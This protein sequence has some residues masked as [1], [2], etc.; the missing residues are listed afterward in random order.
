MIIIKKFTQLVILLQG[1][2]YMLLSDGIDFNKK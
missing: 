2:N 1:E